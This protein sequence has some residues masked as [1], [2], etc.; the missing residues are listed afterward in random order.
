MTDILFVGALE[1]PHTPQDGEG[2]KNRFLMDYFH[3][4]FEKVSYVDTKKWRKN[5]LVLLKLIYYLLFVKIGSI[6]VSVSNPSAYKIFKVLSKL[7]L[8]SKIYYWMIGGYTPIKIKNGIFKPEPFKCIDKI[9]VEADRVCD[10]YKEVGFENTLRVYNFKPFNFIPDVTIPH[11]GIIK[12]F[13][14]SRID[15]LKGVD[16]ILDCVKVIN[17]LGYGDKYR[18]DLYGRVEI[19]AK[20][21][22]EDVEALPNVNYK[23]FLNLKDE[24]NYELL[25]Q[26]D[27][28]LFPTRHLTEGFPG[29][30]ADA[31]IAGVPVIA[32]NWNY[33]E[34][35]IGDNIC[36]M[37]FPMGDKNA[38]KEKM[39]YAI[40]HRDTL[41]KMRATCVS[42]AKNY[43]IENILTDQL[44]YKIGLK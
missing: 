4:Y 15:D 2:I 28:M 7:H 34:E 38:L 16:H 40:N 6:I 10:F 42:K 22:N 23:G 36:G 39:L 41:Q 8:K 31:A 17:E 18:V 44:L 12:F 3:K 11:T 33:A 21:F 1:Y 13:F 20:Q 14:L 5:P 25:S 37:L 19:D 27:A 35:L 32:S 29:A 9:I 43:N 26:Y 24:R 30:I